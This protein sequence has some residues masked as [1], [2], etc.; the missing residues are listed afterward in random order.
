ML[1]RFSLSLFPHPA[2][3]KV[4]ASRIHRFTL[5]LLAN[6]RVQAQ[7]AARGQTNTQKVLLQPAVPAKGHQAFQL[8]QSLLNLGYCARA[9]NKLAF[10]GIVLYAW[11]SKVNWG[12]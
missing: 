10:F 2:S 8:R 3:C 1:A 9:V 4:P 5:L 12:F 11:R 6:G 7:V